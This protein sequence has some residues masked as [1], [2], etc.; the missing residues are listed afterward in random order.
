MRAMCGTV[1]LLASGSRQLSTT[2]GAL[3]GLLF[4]LVATS[5]HASIQFGPLGRKIKDFD[6]FTACSAEVRTKFLEQIQSI[7]LNKLDAIKFEGGLLETRTVGLRLENE[8]VTETYECRAGELWYTVY[9]VLPNMPLAR[10]IHEPSR[11]GF[12]DPV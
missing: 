4:C 6:E 5:A 10:I 7:D 11:Q 3:A 12:A 1:A 2:F 9:S 8:R